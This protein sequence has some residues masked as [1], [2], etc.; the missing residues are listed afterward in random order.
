VRTTSLKGILSIGNGGEDW[1]I[2]YPNR[3]KS[4]VNLVINTQ[5]FNRGGEFLSG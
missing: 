4:L 5:V 1:I 3:V 2:L